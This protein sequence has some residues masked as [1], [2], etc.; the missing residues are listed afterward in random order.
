MGNRDRFIGV[1]SIKFNKSFS[2]DEDCYSYISAIKWE[3]GY[4]CKRCGK[5]KF[6]KGVK[7]FSRRCSSCKYDESPTAGTMFD[8]V[9]FSLLVA[10]HIAFKIST[11]V[12]GMSSLELSHEFELRQPTCWEFKWK[13]QQAMQSSKQYSL[14]GEVHMDEFFIGGQ[15]EQ[16][17]GRSKGKKRLVIIAL[18]KVTDGVGR[19]YAQI[20]EHA[21]AAEFK[22]FFNTYINKDANVITDEWNGYLP[23]KKEYINLKQIP[24]NGGKNF[25]D[26][27]IHIM[28]LKSWLRGIH[29]HC[30]KE[31]LQGYLDEYHYRYNRR[32]N[33][34]T[35]F[36]LL[37]KRMINNE[38]KRLKSNN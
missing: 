33:M 7:P 3:Q 4:K 20:I 26:L 1:N 36:D 18:E 37:I 22:P 19:A 5:E 30:S 8:K 6:M 21:S 24:S 34:D 31:R 16:K 2:S 15:E 17:R 28:N 10:F 12:K 32:N 9:K 35:I 23:L 25:P 14:E 13:I 38:P 11:K 27:H 29:H